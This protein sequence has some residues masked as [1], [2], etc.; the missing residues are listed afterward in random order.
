M[1]S[2]LLLLTLFLSSLGFAQSLI[3][4]VPVQAIDLPDGIGRG[5]IYKTADS[6]LVKGNFIDS[7]VFI[8]QFEAIEDANYYLKIV[9]PGF[10]D[11][12]I[13]F[14]AKPPVMKFEP[15]VLSSDVL[16]DEINVVYE[17][18]VFERTMNGLS[19]NVKGTTLEQLNTLFDILKASPRLSS[20]DDESIEIIG[21]GRPLILIDRQPII[22]ND[23]LRAIPASE[24][25]KIEI[26]TNPSAKY[27]AQ[28]SGNGVIEIYTNDFSLQ[29]Y[30]AHVRLNG[31]INTQKKY[32]SGTNLGLN[33]KRGKF[34][35]NGNLGLNYSENYSFGSSNFATLD[36]SL[37][38]NSS[39]VNEGRHLWNYF[40]LKA[41]Y[42][43][44]E[45]QRISFGIG[46]HGSSGKGTTES[47]QEFY[48]QKTLT[49]N[50]LGETENYNRWLNN[51]AFMNYTW[52]IDSLGSAFEINLNYTRRVSD[53][54]NEFQTNFVDY[55]NQ[56]EVQYNALATSADRPNVGEIR[57]NYEHYIDSNF[58]LEFGVD[59]SA[60]F[61]EKRFNRYVPENGVWVEDPLYTNSYN[62]QE[63][64]A[65]LFAQASRKWGKFGAQ[66]GIRGEYTRLDGFSQ[67]L[68]Q[69]FMDSSY[70]LPFPNAGVMYE[71]GD[72]LAIT[73]YYS[74]G[75]DRPSFSN[76]DPF[77]R[78]L[79][80][81]HV[82]FGNPYLRP[83]YNH[84]IGLE[85]D[86]LYAYNISFSYAR[87]EDIA[88]T[89]T[90]I[91]PN[92][93]VNSSTPWNARLN[94]TYSIS[95]S[96]P[97]KLKWLDG[98]NSFWLDYNT[99]EFTEIFQRDPFNNITMGF[100]S[101][102]T[103][104]LPYNFKLMNRF[105]L[106]KW[107]GDVTINN[108]MTNWGIRLTKEFDKPDINVFAEVNQL[109]PAQNRSE[110]VNGNFLSY[111][112]NQW[113]FTG[114]RVGLFFKFGRLTA[115]TSI[116]ESE[117]GQSGRL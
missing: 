1:K 16:L 66:L 67:S 20:P 79:D 34:S 58:F 96:A 81:L 50:Q 46:G 12:I 44:S 101:F 114:F 107:G 109:F 71:P 25:D 21:R 53:S 9:A 64:I 92:T 8:V 95:L 59:V 27:R 42:D 5:M 43:I 84:T 105:F 74:S 47:H 57:L 83:S 106:N 100:S 37:Y 90:F 29:G 111:G 26:I 19:V 28:G 103:F 33:F 108:V 17:K 93:F 36:S 72:K 52:D 31:G 61:N 94:E 7:N 13:P 68:N 10:V 76:Y 11:T 88:S 89:L 39:Y 69:Q 35:V 113:Q 117:S 38:S 77:V 115:N 62:Y 3:V 6:S 48:S 70:I 14:V 65:G 63:Q 54:D 91:D 75:I 112:Q 78:I 24:V 80:S 87:Y 18:P 45:D 41:G 85:F 110:S 99:Y 22:S 102:L 116:K 86:I 55:S 40:K 73:A 15:V 104:S 97:I 56:T 98:W 30:R 4:E 32:S 2:Y 51:R 82:Q 23:E 60:L 49:T